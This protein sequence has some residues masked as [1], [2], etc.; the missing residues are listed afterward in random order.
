MRDCHS[1]NG[2]YL[3]HA[4]GPLRRIEPDHAVR[5]EEG[6]LVDMGDGASFTVHYRS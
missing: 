4:D 6:D 1:N 3:K 2:T 5:L